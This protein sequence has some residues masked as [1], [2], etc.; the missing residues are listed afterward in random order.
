MSMEI[1]PATAAALAAMG[2]GV[3]DDMTVRRYVCVVAKK[4]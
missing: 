1:A 2:R 4:L 3:L